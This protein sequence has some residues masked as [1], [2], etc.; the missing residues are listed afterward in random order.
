MLLF[1][2][3]LPS[4]S[5]CT[6]RSEGDS[7]QVW[8]QALCY[9]PL[10]CIILHSALQLLH[11]ASCSELCH[12]SVQI[13]SCHQ[14]TNHRNYWLEM[15]N[16]FSTRVNIPSWIQGMQLQSYIQRGGLVVHVGN[17]ANRN[18]R[19]ELKK[20]ALFFEL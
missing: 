7:S 17:G 13:P 4:E 10:S 15:A 2:I 8:R 14:N 1:S 11:S 6:S 19:T 18:N 20:I 16:L 3:F 12:S 5:S 9:N